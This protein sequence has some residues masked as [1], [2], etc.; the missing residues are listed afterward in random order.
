MPP[1]PTTRPIPS[2]LLAIAL[3]AVAVPLAGAAGDA[4]APNATA[5]PEPQE[6]AG[7][8]GN[9]TALLGVFVTARSQT[10]H[11]PVDGATVIVYEPNQTSDGTTA[12]A[13]ARAQTDDGWARFELPT[14]P[15]GIRATDGNLSGHAKVHLDED[16]RVH[17]ELTRHDPRTTHRSDQANTLGVIVTE[18]GPDG[19]V[20]AAGAQV[21]VYELHR[22]GHT[23]KAEPVARETTDERGRAV[24]HLPDGHYGIQAKDGN[25]TD[26]QRLHLQD[27]RRVHLHMAEDRPHRQHGPYHLGIAAMELTDGGLQPVADATITLERYDRSVD[28]GHGWELVLEATTDAEGHLTEALP[29]GFY[30][31]TL[32]TDDGDQSVRHVGLFLDRWVRL[33]VGMPAAQ[34]A[35]AHESSGQASPWSSQ[36]DRAPPA[37]PWHQDNPGPDG[38]H[39]GDA[40]EPREHGAILEQL[41]EI[42]RMLGGLL[43]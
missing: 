2:V 33:Y 26:G 39:R 37:P 31:A 20:P 12:Q 1:R 35:H 40:D 38:D 18:P 14:G 7:A 21:T 8:H 23:A 34:E 30:R 42:R 4:T 22:R 5:E 3:V 28:R 11:G 17:I 16:K 29:A 10:H 6:G 27:D 41:V 13:V 9:G 15:Y 25:A 43:G 36:D 19:P 24:F 32:T